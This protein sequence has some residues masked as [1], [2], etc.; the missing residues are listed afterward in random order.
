MNPLQKMR[1]MV[2]RGVVNLI[3]DAGGLQILQI[4]ALE[5]ETR[6]GVERAQNFGMSSHPPVG[7]EPIMVAVG[8]SR[9]HLVAVAVDN[10]EHRPKG[11]AEGE[12][13]VYSAHDSF[14]HFDADG[15]VTLKCKK[16][17]VDASE[18]T[19]V[20]TPEA[21]FSAMASVNGL[22]SF[23]N[24]MAGVAGDNGIK[25]AGTYYITGDVVINGIKFSTHGHTG[26]MAGGDIAGGPV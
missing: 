25:L 8:G 10:E 19:E 5:N 12:V 2:A 26:V 7:S 18:K 9:N 17:I 3:D 13:K 21:T 23:N 15:N 4:T 24:G 1:L 6:D 11:L 22:F 14:L 20:N 16:F